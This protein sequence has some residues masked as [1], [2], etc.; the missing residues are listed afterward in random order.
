MAD[1]DAF[2]AAK[3]IVASHWL[4]QGGW[5]N[6]AYLFQPG[7]QYPVGVV[8]GRRGGEGF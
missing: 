6:P 5:Q 2:S 1:F 7:V 3:E 4:L 8:G